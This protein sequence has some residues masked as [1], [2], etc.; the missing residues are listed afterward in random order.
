MKT[1]IEQNE[2]NDPAYGEASGTPTS[3]TVEVELSYV[4][5]SW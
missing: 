5:V 3:Q 1:R 4:D 2:P